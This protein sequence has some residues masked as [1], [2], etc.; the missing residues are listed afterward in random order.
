[1]ITFEIEVPHLLGSLS[2]PPQKRNRVNALVNTTSGV[3]GIT[4][5]EATVTG[6]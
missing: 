6:E 3:S 2:G 1:L 5:P 4:N